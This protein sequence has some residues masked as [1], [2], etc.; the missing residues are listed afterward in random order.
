M[1]FVFI[2]IYWCP[3]RFLISYD[4]RVFNSNTTG[5]TSGEETANSYGAPV[6]T[7]GF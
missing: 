3:T 1:L 4:V 5:V 7:P 6:F 2:Y